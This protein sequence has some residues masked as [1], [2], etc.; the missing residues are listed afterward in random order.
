MVRKVR[1]SD[2]TKRT[3][4]KPEPVETR[5]LAHPRVWQTVVKLCDG[6][7]TRVTVEGYGK[8]TVTLP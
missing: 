7:M 2:P 1:A 4:R 5:H 3:R 6:D 8:V